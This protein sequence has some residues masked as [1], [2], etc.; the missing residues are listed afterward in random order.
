MSVGLAFLLTFAVLTDLRAH[1]IPNALTALGLVAGLLL[2]SAYGGW[3]GLSTGVLGALVGL[4]VLLPFHVLKGM[5]AGDVKL[6]AAAGAYLSPGT[7]LFGAL[8][9]LVAGGVCALLWL[10]V[11][12]P[13]GLLTPVDSTGGPASN[14]APLKRTRFPY[15]VAI[16]TGMTFAALQGGT[17]AAGLP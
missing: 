6:A 15:A 8:A 5:G 12:R 14:D 7:A 17:R 9:T 4:G 13:Q 16:A 3:H 10:A 1:R 11:Q 2:Q